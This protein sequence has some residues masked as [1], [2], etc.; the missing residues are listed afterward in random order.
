MHFALSTLL[1]A[2]FAAVTMAVAPAF[3]DVIIS[4][5]KDAPGHLLED[6]KEK[7]RNTKGAKITHEYSS[8][9]YS[10]AVCLSTNGTAYKHT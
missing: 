7:V 3:H 2:L 1:L 8:S 9:L 4:F 6:A 10:N 5:P